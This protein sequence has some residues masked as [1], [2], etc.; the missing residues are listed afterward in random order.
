MYYMKSLQLLL[1][2]KA[3]IKSRFFGRENVFEINKRIEKALNEGV[4]VV[5]L[6]DEDV[7]Q[8]NEQERIKLNTLRQKYTNVPHVILATSKPSIEYWFLLHY[9]DT[10]RYFET[11][12]D[13]IK[14]L[15]KSTPF[16]KTERYLTDKSWVEDLISDDK[17]KNAYKR[18]RKYAGSQMSHTNVYLMLDKLLPE[19]FTDG[20]KSE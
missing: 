16:S 2:F 1:G 12:D 8:W 10:N 15:R 20:K 13:V 9:T 7:T 4:D 5:C 18:A 11:S 17:M 3:E 19:I 14:E 6:F